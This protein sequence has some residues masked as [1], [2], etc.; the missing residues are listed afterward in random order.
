MR[1]LILLRHAK[2]DYPPGVPDR[3]RPLSPRGERDAIAAA[4]W[5]G[6]A[7]PEVDEA[8][9]SP[10]RRAAQT[11]NAVQGSVGDPAVRVDERVYD[12]WGAGLP[13]VVT[14][15]DP[16]SRT[17]LIIGH[18]PGIEDLAQALAGQERSDARS[19]LAAKYPTAGIAVIGFSGEWT[20]L[21]S[22]QL[23]VF[24]VPRGL[25]SA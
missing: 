8:I 17:A 22:T 15:I 9:V 4:R 3:E 7:F 18:N 5:L 23:L 10:A 6:A 2:S 21:R 13:Q 11:W 19:R 12:D 25:H 16:G 20:D 14:G 24:A 1:Q